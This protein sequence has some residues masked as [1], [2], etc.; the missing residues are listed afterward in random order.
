MPVH[1]SLLL[2]CLKRAKERLWRR[3]SIASSQLKQADVAYF[4]RKID[5]LKDVYTLK[6]WHRNLHHEH[7]EG[8]TDQLSQK[9]LMSLQDPEDR[10][11]R[12]V[13]Q[14]QSF[15]STVLH[16][17][18]PLMAVPDTLSDDTIT[19]LLRQ[20]CI[21]PLDGSKNNGG[22]GK[23]IQALIEADIFGNEP[24][25]KDFWAEQQRK[26]E[27]VV[28]YASQLP[29]IIF[30][31]NGTMRT[32]RDGDPMVVVLQENKHENLNCVHELSWRVTTKDAEQWSA[33]ERSFGGGIG[34]AMSANTLNHSHH[35]QL[36][37]T[38]S[39]EGR[40]A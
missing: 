10:L 34:W 31:E 38:K 8:F 37:K 24:T 40:F 9:L 13:L 6:K 18:D 16:A 15:D 36:W 28:I 17:R 22:K 33:W 2:C 20:R 11:A 26:S 35:A 1:T 19:K 23:K 5:F 3:V 25:A 14:R 12:R 7:F 21:K 39:Q 32:A 4:I 27:N 30:Y 29:N